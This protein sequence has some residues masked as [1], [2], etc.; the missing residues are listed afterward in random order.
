MNNLKKLCDTALIAEFLK[1]AWFKFG[2]NV[3]LR[4]NSIIEIKKMTKYTT[5]GKVTR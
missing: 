4:A 1:T 5:P 3:A 2:G